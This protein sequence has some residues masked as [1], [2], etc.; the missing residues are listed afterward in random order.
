[1]C[2]SL[3]GEC[4]MIY[5]VCLG[6]YEVTSWTPRPLQKTDLSHRKRLV[7]TSDASVLIYTPM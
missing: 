4:D 7:V 5:F 3:R 1:M 6:F 2:L